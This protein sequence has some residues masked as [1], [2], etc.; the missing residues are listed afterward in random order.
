MV[1]CYS[2]TDDGC[3][4]FYKLFSDYYQ[5]LGCDEDTE[6]L[7]DEYVV[8]DCKAGLLSICLIDDDEETVGFAI[9][10]TDRPENE[11]CEKE[12]WGNIRELYIAPASRGKGLG[13]FLL[14][15]CEMFLGE[16]GA[17]NCYCLPADGTEGF[18]ISCGYAESEERCEELDCPFFIKELG[19]TQ[20]C[21]H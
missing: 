18:F 21:N 14:K 6:H 5:E 13:T 8:A 3:R 20:C 2:L 9:Y 17:K 4:Q 10:Q 19:K 12:G 15:T 7:L 11:W 1:R 16:S